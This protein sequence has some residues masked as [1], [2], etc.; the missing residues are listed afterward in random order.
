MR[1]ENCQRYFLSGLRP[2]RNAPPH[3]TDGHKAPHST[4]LLPRPYGCYPATIY[5]PCLAFTEEVGEGIDKGVA[6]QTPAMALVMFGVAVGVAGLLKHGTQLAHRIEQ[7]L[8]TTLLIGVKAGL[9]GANH[10]V[11][12]YR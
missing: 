6:P 7:V 8:A 12:A 9:V 11:Q 2:L 5:K 4:Q 10:Q 1:G 3:P